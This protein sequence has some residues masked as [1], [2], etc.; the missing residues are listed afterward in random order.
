VEVEIDRA[1]CMGSGNCVFEAPGVFELDDDGIAVVVDPNAASE[2]R[3][4]E[5]AR[6]C[7]TSAISVRRDGAKVV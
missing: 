5:T 7:P 1:V 4:I 3:I 2:E 6:V